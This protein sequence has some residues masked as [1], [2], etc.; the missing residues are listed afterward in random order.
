[1]SFIE[2]VQVVGDAR[3]RE[4]LPYFPATA[5]GADA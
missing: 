5:K 1:V 3:V 4:R 2:Y